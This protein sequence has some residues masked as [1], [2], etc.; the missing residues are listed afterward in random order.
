MRRRW[1]GA[2]VGGTFLGTLLGAPNLV[3]QLRAEPVSLTAYK[4]VVEQ[5]TK[6]S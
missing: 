2:W 1:A 3:A 6:E 4:A 5:P